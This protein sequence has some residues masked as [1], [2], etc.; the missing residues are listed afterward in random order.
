V[1]VAHEFATPLGNARLAENVLSGHL[2]GLSESESCLDRE[3]IQSPL[4]IIE[5]SIERMI[6]LLERFKDLNLN[7][8]I[9]EHYTL[10]ADELIN[11]LLIEAAERFQVRKDDINLTLQSSTIDM[12]LP[13]VLNLVLQELIENSL[14]H[15][16]QLG[17]KHT[18]KWAPGTIGNIRI[19]IEKSAQGVTM[20]YACDGLPIHDTMA[21][22]IFE[23][24]V[25]SK[26]MDGRIGLGLFLVRGVMEHIL[27]G[28][29]EL[30]YPLPEKGIAYILYW[31]TN[32]RDLYPQKS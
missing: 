23:P 3:E 1:G 15:S 11:F 4:N 21:D 28:S 32:Y 19:E 2:N 20:K 24:F 22:T 12:Q 31:P 6:R 26:R 17:S 27:N 9:V 18:G 25:T 10:N 5:I 30:S 7:N 13:N 8:V 14:C 29:I 16:F